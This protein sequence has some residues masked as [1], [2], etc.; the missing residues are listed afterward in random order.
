MNRTGAGPESDA[1]IEAANRKQAEY[2]RRLLVE[3]R[4][5]ID[6]AIVEYVDALGKGGKIDIASARELRQIIRKAERER[7]A[8]D[9]MIT[10]IDER[11]PIMQRPG[12]PDQSPADGRPL[13]P[14]SPRRR[15]NIAV[16]RSHDQR[17]S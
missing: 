2:Y 7:Q 10:V 5:E 8:V 11:F 17:V 3:H 15:P 9:R 16:D 14:M 13:V 6:H 1:A 12:P 4:E